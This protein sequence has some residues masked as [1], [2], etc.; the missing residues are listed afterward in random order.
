[1]R[2]SIALMGREWRALRGT[3]LGL[4]L[5]SPLLIDLMAWQAS[6]SEWGWKSDLRA[7][8]ILPIVAGL[9][10]SVLC[11]RAF[12]DGP[13][14]RS[15]LSHAAVSR[16]AV[17]LAK[18]VIAS[19][20]ALGITGTLVLVEYLRALADTEHLDVFLR[21][22]S[23]VQPVQLLGAALA[24]GGAA[25]AGALGARAFPATVIGVAIGILPLNAIGGT[26]AG[27][28]GLLLQALPD[29]ALWGPAVLAAPLA[30]G[31][32]FRIGPTRPGDRLRSAGLA[33]LGLGLVL[34]CAGL[35]VVREHSKA[36]VPRLDR[37][38]VHRFSPSPDGKY[39][40]LELT[41]EWR[42]WRRQGQDRVSFT[43]VLDSDTGEARHAF[44]A[45]YELTLLAG[46]PFGTSWVDAAHLKVR[47]EVGEDR[48]MDLDLRTGEFAPG[49]WLHSR[50]GSTE[51]SGPGQWTLW[52][53][54]HEPEEQELPAAHFARRSSREGQVLLLSS[55]GRLLRYDVSTSAT[56]V[57]MEGVDLDRFQTVNEFAGGPVVL[58]Y[59]G[60]D[61]L[62]YE[63]W[64]LDPDD[65][66]VLH[67]TEPGWH[68]YA[69]PG[70]ANLVVVTEPVDNHNNQGAY[71]FRFVGTEGSTD[72]TRPD[73]LGYIQALGPD[74]LI[75][76]DGLGRLVVLDPTGRQER[77]LFVPGGTDV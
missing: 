31:L 65:G 52:W 30:A 64:V 21:G 44:D 3:A 61:V 73:Y 17:V 34:G 58:E 63:C 26:F 47:R 32:A 62:S 25:L 54:D 72:Y 75:A 8:W 50:W 27:P 7:R 16:A 67:K 29:I 66:R 37:G 12:A 28:I 42:H 41:Q 68:V 33:A 55:E 9:A 1:M 22:L 69:W 77:V 10:W 2:R 35:V 76:R 53:R 20:I 45:G 40:A 71:R 49:M 13:D 6:V 51:G 74:R 59:C 48:I 23:R 56:S 15:G 36:L 38:Y 24:A 11:A 19:L 43:W 18:F 4:V 5:L 14:T 57:L 70:I 46:P 60:E 39:V